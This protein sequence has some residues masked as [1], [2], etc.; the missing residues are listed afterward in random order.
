MG[1]DQSRTASSGLLAELME[2][3]D[4]ARIGHQK[5]PAF[6]LQE[7]RQ[8][9]L[10]LHDPLDSAAAAGSA[11]RKPPPPYPGPKGPDRHADDPAVHSR[12]TKDA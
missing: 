12:V 2:M 3:K 4:L 6:D 8:A 10:E 5:R 11:S 1:P 7:A 9:P